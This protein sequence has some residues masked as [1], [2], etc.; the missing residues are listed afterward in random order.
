MAPSPQAPGAPRRGA[1]PDHVI[2]P[3]EPRPS[4][5]FQHCHNDERR[6]QTPGDLKP[7]DADIAAYPEGEPGIGAADGDRLRP[8]ALTRHFND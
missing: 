5:G 2:R 1:C 8:D 6:H 4:A 7:P 3:V